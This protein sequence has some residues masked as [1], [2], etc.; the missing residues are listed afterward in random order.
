MGKKS[1]RKAPREPQTKAN[2]SSW[3]STVHAGP[4]SRAGA[5]MLDLPAGCERFRRIEEYAE[6]NGTAEFRQVL[7]EAVEILDDPQAEKDPTEYVHLVVFPQ[8]KSNGLERALRALRRWPRLKPHWRRLRRR[9]CDYCGSQYGLSEPRLEVCGGCGVARYCN[10]ACQ[11]NDFAHHENRCPVIARQWHGVGFFPPSLI[12]A[13]LDGTW[14]DPAVIPSARA[15][16][17]IK[18]I[19]PSLYSAVPSLYSAVNG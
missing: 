14:Q 1:R 8:L 18:Q 4:C 15:R 17:H 12:H 7:T 9:V 10:E 13:V 19:I 5:G 3:P 11:A 6:S 2:A 16:E